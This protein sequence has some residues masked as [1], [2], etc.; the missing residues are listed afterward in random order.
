MR[1]SF[2]RVPPRPRLLPCLITKRL[3]ISSCSFKGFNSPMPT[4][5]FKVSQLE[6]TDWMRL[7]NLRIKAIAETP[8]W[9]SGNLEDETDYPESHW[10]EWATIE[11]WCVVKTD[12][13]DVGVME[14][15]STQAGEPIRRSDCWIHN[16]WIEPSVRGLGVPRLMIA[17]LDDLCEIRGWSKQGLGVWPEN[18]HAIRA[19]EK[20]GFAI[21]GVPRPTMRNPKQMFVPMFREILHT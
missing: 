18:T 13:H 11:S 7:R 4:H 17:W 21:E 1:S 10:I 5:R 20:L 2:F 15:Q 19:Y 3:L 9:I 16:C 8:R 14:V 12:S 6:A